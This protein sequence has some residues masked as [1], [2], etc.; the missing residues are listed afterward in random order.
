MNGRPTQPHRKILVVGDDKS[1]TRVLGIALSSQGYTVQ[2]AN[3]GVQGLVRVKSWHP[4]LVMC[5]LAM[6]HMDGFAFL[7][8]MR[9]FTDVPVII[10]S[11]EKGLLID[12]AVIAAGA[13]LFVR[14]PF[15]MKALDEA[16]SSQLA[17]TGAA[18]VHH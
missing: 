5:D 2:T 16:I 4:D 15:E 6:P 18:S 8:R 12:S 9:C 14:K 3:D 1:L 10:L 17:N 13:N 7:S 11:G